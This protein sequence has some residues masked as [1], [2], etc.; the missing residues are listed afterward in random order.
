MGELYHLE[1]A[2]ARDETETRR[3]TQ[4]HRDRDTEMSTRI[5]GI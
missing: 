3:Q 5:Y 1:R 2:D 4:R